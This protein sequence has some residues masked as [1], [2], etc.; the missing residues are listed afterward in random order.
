MFYA[1]PF[2]PSGKAT[3]M[4]SLPSA[5]HARIVPFICSTS[6]LEMA[7]PSP[8]EFRAAST[9]K[10]RSEQPPHLEIVQPCRRVRKDGLAAVRQG[11]LQ[12]AVAVGQRVV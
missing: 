12:I 9:E 5:Y 7:S 2:A 6:V 3:A 8:V 4:C 11:D 1:F 10:K